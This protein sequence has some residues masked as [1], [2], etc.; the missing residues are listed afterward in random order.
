MMFGWYE[1]TASG[2][3]EESL[4]PGQRELVSRTAALLRE[5]GAE[6]LELPAIRT[7]SLW[8]IRAV[9]TQA[10][11]HI[12]DSYEWLVFTS[13]AGVEGIL[14]GNSSAM[15]EDR[16]ACSLEMVQDLAVI[17]EGTKEEISGREESICGFHAF[18]YMMEIPLE[19]N[20]PRL[21]QTEEKRS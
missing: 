5:K 1:R 12:L 7:V 2:R 17:G 13:P 10:L 9:C 20:L 16:P 11:A 6:V 18:C 21:F 19:K 15:E 3:L 8:R 4:S 14:R